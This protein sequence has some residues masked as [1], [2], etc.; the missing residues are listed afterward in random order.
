M[1]VCLGSL[2]LNGASD[3][4]SL[5]EQIPGAA[6]HISQ[7]MKEEAI[8]VARAAAAEAKAAAL[9][10]DD[11]QWKPNKN[12]KIAT[13]KYVVLE[14]AANGYTHPNIL[15]AKLGQRLWA[16]DAPMQKRQRFDEITRS[17]TNGSHGFRVAGMRVFQGSDDASE[18]D[19][20]GYKSYEK[21]YGRFEVTPDNVVDEMRK[22]IFVP[23]AGI[24][25]E[26]GKRVAAAFVEDLRTVERILVNEESRMYSASLLFTYEGHGETLRAAMEQTAQ[27]PASPTRQGRSAPKSGAVPDLAT[28][29]VDSGIEL[30]DEVEFANPGKDAGEDGAGLTGHGNGVICPIPEQVQVIQFGTGGV[31]SDSQPEFDES[32]DEGLEEDDEGLLPSGPKIHS[33]KLIDFAHAE[34]TPGRGPDENCLVGVRS[35]IRIFEQLSQ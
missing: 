6:D 35:L 16:D 31:D 19:A 3:I 8:K 25:E 20:A 9:S 11:V 12:K 30:D 28:S 24:D 29:R 34:W 15:D 22:F 32:Y 21:D 33:L 13:N 18:L 14:N 17:T 5:D 10:P 4:K 26:L 2:A 1:P 23:Q 27:P 7:G